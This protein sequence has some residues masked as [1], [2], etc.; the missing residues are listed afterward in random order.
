MSLQHFSTL[1]H[2]LAFAVHYFEGYAANINLETF[3]GGLLLS[4]NM[5][6]T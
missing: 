2:F 1:T 4:W 5:M 3:S 6:G